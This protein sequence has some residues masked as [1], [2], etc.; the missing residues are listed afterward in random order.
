MIFKDRPHAGIELSKRLKDYADRD[1]V[2]V[3]ALPR[4]GVPVAFEVAKSLRAPLD[5]L[6][7]R[8]LGMR[9][10]E[11]VAIGAVAGDGVRVLNEDLLEQA[12]MS[13][14]AV[15]SVVKRER[16]E[17]DRR[18]AAYRMGRPQLGIAGKTVIVVDDGL[19][20]GATMRAAVAMLR[21]LAPERVIVAVP[22]V[23]ESA[24]EMLRAEVDAVICAKTPQPFFG[25]GQWYENFNQI[26]DEQVR[27]LLARAFE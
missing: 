23:T 4:G 6:V 8:K 5:V 18:E 24:C 11:E 25:V 20:T 16:L 14:A 22:V 21:N 10:Q 7:V 1:D 17:L 26:D 15:E 27:D 12:G 13:T 19:A 9:G 2:L 3:L